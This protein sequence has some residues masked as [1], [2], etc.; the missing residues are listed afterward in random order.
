MDKKKAPFRFYF[1]AVPFRFC[2][3]L[4]ADGKFIYSIKFNSID[5]SLDFG[6]RWNSAADTQL[7]AEHKTL[8]ALYRHSYSS[9]NYQHMNKWKIK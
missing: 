6:L 2:Y 3:F 4:V 8:R 1:F 9:G 7:F 5:I